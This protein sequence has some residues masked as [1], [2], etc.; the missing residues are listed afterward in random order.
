M[1]EYH[2]K[3]CVDASIVLKLLLPEEDAHVAD[4]LWSRWQEDHVIRYAPTSLIS[5]TFHGI[6]RNVLR[7]R[8]TPQEGDDA[9]ARVIDLPIF[10]HPMDWRDGHDVWHRFVRQFDYLVT[11]YDAAY[12]YVAEAE[13]CDFWTADERLVRTVSGEL[14]WVR[15][16]SEVVIQE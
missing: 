9:V 11:P 13:G 16:L 10:L 1:T 6:R 15:A 7:E 14:P 8:L 2:Q 4:S 5:E 3:V 12:L